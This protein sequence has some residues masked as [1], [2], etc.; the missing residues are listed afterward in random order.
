MRWG[1]LALAAL[2]VSFLTGCPPQADN[3]GNNDDD[4]PPV[5]DVDDEPAPPR[6]FAGPTRSSTI[7]LTSDDR[8]LVVANRDSDSVSIVEVRDANGADVANLIVELGVGVEPRYV[9]ITPDDQLAFVTNAITS[10]VSVIALDGDKAFRVIDE[11]NVGTEPRG[12]A[13]TPNGKFLFVA[14]HTSDSVSV[15]NIETLQVI[16]EVIVG[17]NPTAIA[18]TNNGDDSDDDETVFVTQF[19]AELIANGPG[20]T[21]DDGKQGVVNALTVGNLV[22]GPTRILLSPLADAGFDADRKAFCKQL[23]AAAAFD[24]FCPDTTVADAANAVIAADPQ[25]CYP[26]QLHAALVRGDRVYIP[27][28]APQPEPPIKFNVNLQALVSVIDAGLLVENTVERV[29][30][31]DQIKAE[32]QPD[33]AVANTVLTRLFAADTVALDAD[34]DGENFLFVSRGGNYVMRATLADGLLGLGAPNIVRFQ[35]GNLP[36]GVV[37]SADGTRAYTNNEVGFS[38][39]AIDLEGNVVLARDISC[40]EPP[41]PGTFAHSALVG[42][43]C[44]FTSLGIPDNG[45]FGTPIRDIVPLV[46]RNKASDNGWSSCSSCH[47]DGLHDGVTWIFATGPR[48]TVS[49]DAFFGKDNPGDQKISNW[50]AVRGSVTDFNENSVVVQGGK[51]FAGD[52]INPNVYNHGMKQGISDALDAQTLWVQTVRTLVLPEGNSDVIARGRQVFADNCASCHGGAKWTKSQIV[53]ADNPTF[54]A[55]PLAAMPGVPRDAGI[56]SPAA[57]QIRSY[58]SAGQTIVMIENI[59]TFSAANPIEIRNNATLAAGGIG[60]NVPSLLGIKYTAPYFHNGSAQTL[61]EVFSGH[62]L[63]GGTIASEISA[64]ERA[65]LL[66]FLETIDG[67]TETFT[68]QTD[69]FLQAIGG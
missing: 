56:D 43:L 23:N 36:N 62:A 57:G 60:F 46:S 65:D 21:F 24:T 9:A 68:S 54:T 47:P 2:S 49:L 42:K 55:N 38:V 22:A 39:T 28:I 17:G 4:V 20:E 12:C 53:W 7:A 61:G 44:F 34:L 31:N 16:E 69:T 6:K 11:I 14:N 5:D 15:I 33:A 27:S 64:S 3:G 10:T 26:N 18:I 19:Y 50:N 32:T 51:G 63:G 40:S 8:F 1:A 13:V 67:A 58:A 52:P 41:F 25:A 66:A 45:I 30:L 59:G 29:N 35:T 48:Q 37:M